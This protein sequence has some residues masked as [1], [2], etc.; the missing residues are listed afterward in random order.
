[1]K[2]QYQLATALLL[3][4]TLVSCG[5]FDLMPKPKTTAEGIGLAITSITSMRGEV[6]RQLETARITAPQA[7]QMQDVLNQARGL[8]DTATFALETGSESDAIRYLDLATAV[9]EKLE[10][11]LR[12]RS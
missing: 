12:E 4:L 8:A 10:E 11:V 2:R 6:R 9:L 5:I 7:Q 1:M 3:T